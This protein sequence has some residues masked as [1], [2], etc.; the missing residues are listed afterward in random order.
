GAGGRGHD[1][2]PRRR[3]VRRRQAVRRRCQHRQAAGVGGDVAC[4]RYLPA[5]LWRVRLCPRVRHR[6]QVARGPALSD[7]ADI[8]QPDPGLYRSACAGDAKVLLTS[9]RTGGATMTG[10]TRQAAEF[11]SAI[12]AGDVPANLVEVAKS[13]ITDCVA[14]MIAG[15][16]EEPPRLVAG[17]VAPADGDGT[18]P[19]RKSV[20]EGRS[21]EK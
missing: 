12:T 15:S 10:L 21:V 9:L 6:T 13:G 3:A 14:V 20:A 16:G 11:V 19:D 2:P 1:V 18:A 5:D 17:M 8:D 7:C 4:C